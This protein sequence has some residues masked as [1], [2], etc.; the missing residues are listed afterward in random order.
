MQ[1]C[2][3]PSISLHLDCEATLHLWDGMLL[4]MPYYYEELC[5]EDNGSQKLRLTLQA[6]GTVT[7][8]SYGILRASGITGKPCPGGPPASR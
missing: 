6:Q 1:R 2:L 7:A 8:G 4:R 5:E 3:Y